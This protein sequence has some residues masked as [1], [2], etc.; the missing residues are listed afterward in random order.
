MKDTCKYG[1]EIR[2]R[3]DRDGTGYCRVCRRERSRRDNR[4]RREQDRTNAQMAQ[5]LTQIVGIS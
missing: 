5:L 3:S 4:K 2:L 1:H